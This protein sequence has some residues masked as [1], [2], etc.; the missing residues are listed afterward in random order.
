MGSLYPGRPEPLDTSHALVLPVQKG[1]GPGSITLSLAC[2]SAARRV[3]LAM[4]GA[5]K[6]D[7]VRLC[8]QDQQAPGA[9]PAQMVRCP[10]GEV[11]WLLDAGAASK[12]DAAPGVAALL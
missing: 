2:M 7:A 10:A 9:F 12:L 11:T 4:S 3:V 1:S 5:S 6:A 8:L